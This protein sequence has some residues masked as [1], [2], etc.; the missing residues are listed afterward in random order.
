MDASAVPESA[1]TRLDGPDADRQTEHLLDGL[2]K[3]VAESGE[4]RLFRWGKLAGLFPS[5]IGPSGTAATFAIREGLLES[6]RSE[7]KGKLVVEWVRATPRAVDY[8][9]QN[10]SPRAVL[11]EI[12][13]IL[14]Q[15]R[16]G[17]PDW[18][19]HARDEA[20]QLAMRFEHQSREILRRLDALNERVEAA[21]RRLEVPSAKLSEP[22]GQLIP[23]GEKALDYLDRRAS[24]TAQA[25]P[26]PELFHAI[27][28][29][30]TDITLTAFHDGLRR[31]SDA[32]LLRLQEASPE[33]I[34]EPEYALLIQ[35][36]MH[37]LVSR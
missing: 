25:C 14:G 37:W 31:L 10:D 35:G 34:T 36:R 11:R 27:R 30:L 9:H 12:H 33:S 21:L 24:S 23:W 7:Q 5:R 19:H 4:H 6:V 32:R 8:L 2:K 20:A 1:P 18:M 22:M 16:E 15:T 29:E 17:I 3:A 28:A 13:Q 26:L